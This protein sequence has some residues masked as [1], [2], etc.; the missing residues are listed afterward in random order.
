MSKDVYLNC[1][2]FCSWAFPHCCSMK[3][4]LNTVLRGRANLLQEKPQSTVG[5]GRRKALSATRFASLI[6]QE[7]Q[8]HRFV[9]IFIVSQR[10]TDMPCLVSTKRQMEKSVQKQKSTN[11][12]ILVLR[13]RFGLLCKY[14][15][16]LLKQ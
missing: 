5:T 14:Q 9:L 16:L 8:F 15:L 3:S 1:F 12:F 11:K 13:K 2:L 7:P 10:Q 6:T 4:V